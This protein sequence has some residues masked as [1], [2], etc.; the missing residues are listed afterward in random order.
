MRLTLDINKSLK[1]FLMILFIIS[2]G[3][4][5]GIAYSRITDTIFLS[6]AA[7]MFFF[8]GKGALCNKRASKLWLV[9]VV[10]YFVNF[11]IFLNDSPN[12]SAY[13]VYVMRMTACMLLCN[14]LTLAEF[15][16]LF[17][18]AVYFISV[19]SLIAFVI[20]LNTNYKEYIVYMNDLPVLGVFNCKA[21]PTRRNSSIFWEPGA[22]QL[23]INLALLFHLEEKNFTKKAIISLET[24]LLVVSLITTVSTS[25]YFAFAFVVLYGI[26][27]N[28]DSMNKRNK[29]LAIMPMI[30]VASV[31]IFMILTSSA[32]VDKFQVR[33]MSFIRRQADVYNSLE[34][35]GDS[36]VYGYGIGTN[37]YYRMTEA[38]SLHSNSIGVFASA[39]NLGTIYSFLFLFGLLHKGFNDYK[40]IIIPYIA[41]IIITAV[42]EDFFRYSIYFALL[43]GFNTAFIEIK[44][45]KEE[46][47]LHT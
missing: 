27:K 33:N 34:A 38:H 7:I 16:H 20:I 12:I 45:N 1:S 21:I 46:R 30:A 10:F 9:T 39:L 44:S 4:V 29:V 28:W 6:I 18:R 17:H 14:T 43:Y 42:T 31:A 35:I 24:I 26:I 5:I 22:Y 41:I 19:I 25:G 32:V 37:A 11:I 15:K 13:F 40:S 8:C 23:F 2:S 3:S 47:L 36:P